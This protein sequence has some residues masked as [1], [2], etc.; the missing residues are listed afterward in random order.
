MDFTYAGVNA[1]V[2]APTEATFGDFKTT[3]SGGTYIY[4]DSSSA[5][6]FALTSDITHS[7]WHISGTVGTY[8]GFGLYWYACAL[9]DASA[10]KG[11]SMTISGNMPANTLYISVDTAEDEVATAWYVANTT[12]PATAGTFGTCVPGSNLY[13]G[14]CA[15]P[16]TAIPVAATPTAVT[17][18][19]A[20]LTGGKPQ[21]SVSPSKLTGISF[22]FN[23][24]FSTAPFPVDITI[25]DL[26]FVP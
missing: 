13:D 21:A 22:Y 16:S 18:L 4:P 23:Y 6:L 24:S 17:I 20:D 10:F 5:T 12:T 3:F 1:G 7:N 15:V 8:S 19:W 2:A 11:I 9:L 14:T 26:S 25:D